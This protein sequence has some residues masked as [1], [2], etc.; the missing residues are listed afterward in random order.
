LENG[1]VRALKGTKY[2]L[3]DLQLLS[4][5]KTAINAGALPAAYMPI[6]AQVTASGKL[7]NHFGANGW[8]WLRSNTPADTFDYMALAAQVDGKV[9]VATSGGDTVTVMRLN[10]DGELDSSFGSNGIASFDVYTNNIATDSSGN[11]WP[12]FSN[13]RI[14]D[15]AIQEDGKI[16][17]AGEASHLLPFPSS[18]SQVHL[19]VM[20]LNSSGALDTG[21]SGDGMANYHSSNVF[22]DMFGR[23]VAVKGTGN[24]T[25][26]VVAGNGQS[27]APGLGGF[28]TQDFFVAKIQNNGQL[29]SNFGSG[30]FASHDFLSLDTATGTLSSNDDYPLDIGIDSQNRIIVVGSTNSAP[31]AV[32]FSTTGTVGI[33]FNGSLN[34][35]NGQFS[36]VSILAN[37]SLVAAGEIL[38]GSTKD[39]LITKVTSAGALDTS[40]GAGGTGFVSGNFDNNSNS[41]DQ[42]FGLTTLPDGSIIGAG[43][44]QPDP[45]SNANIDT[46]LVKL[47]SSGALVSTFGPGGHRLENLAGSSNETDFASKIVT[48]GSKVVTVGRARVPQLSKWRIAVARF[49]P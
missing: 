3:N 45:N 20:R 39:Y 16:V 47:N 17:L 31:A 12:R 33:Q 27:L 43:R 7:D 22:G 18:T 49:N 11:P 44:Y 14:W 19:F 34:S 2:H 35:L 38:N 24:S 9:V 41:V 32:R 4:Q 15:A 1:T 28:N 5:V 6:P 40:F 48:S 25:Q 29:D 8:R 37:D 23:A 30:G 21:F 26:I 46:A 13:P 36:A 10:T 42:I